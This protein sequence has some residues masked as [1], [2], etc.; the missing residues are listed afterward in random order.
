MS[1]K[2]RQDYEQQILQDIVANQQSV[3]KVTLFK[4]GGVVRGMVTAVSGVLQDITNDILQ[5]KRGRALDTCAILSDGTSPDLDA[6]GDERGIPR[7]GASASSV[8]VVFQ[9][10]DGT[11]IPAGQQILTSGLASTITFTTSSQITLG[12]ANP[13]ITGLKSVGFGNAV[14]C[15]STT[16]GVATK[17]PSGTLTV[18]SPAIA[19]V[20]C[21]NPL[22]AQ[23]GTDQE[24]SVNY[25]E[26]MRDYVNLMAQGTQAF[27]EALAQTFDASILRAYAAFDFSST[28]TKVSVLKNDGT[29]LDGTS[30]TNLATY[31][32]TKQRAVEPVSCVNVTV[33]GLTISVKAQFE[34][35]ISAATG[36]ANIANALC[37]FIDWTTWVFGKTVR[38]AD[39]AEV[40]NNALGVAYIDLSTLYVNNKQQDVPISADSLPRFVALSIT[41]IDTNETVNYNLTQTWG[42]M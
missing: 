30:L 29:G 3:N 15:T 6:Y 22:P 11:V 38:Y 8:I 12:A 17:V 5:F 24:D 37:D 16:T 19:G 34:P 41:T 13:G 4:V 20:T 23:G 1:L 39:L 35:G 9:G 42:G 2:T 18:L 40:I 31:I 10:P 27:Y 21:V 32:A 26:R 14:I 7:N 25:R 28:G 36:Y 33:T